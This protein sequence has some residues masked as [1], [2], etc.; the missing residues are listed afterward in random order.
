MWEARN[1][2]LE[3][4]VAIKILSDHLSRNKEVLQRF[5][6]EA[7]LSARAIHP[8]IVHVEDIGHTEEHVPFLVMEL[9]RGRSLLEVI[10]FRGAVS[11]KE[12]VAVLEALLD[13][14]AAAHARGILHRDVKPGNVFIVNDPETE[15]PVKILDLGL[16]KDLDGTFGLTRSEMVMGTPDYLAPELLTIEQKH[17]WS[18][19]ADVFA[20]GVIGYRLLGGRRPLD[21]HLAPDSSPLGFI[22]R[23]RFFKERF[24]AAQWADDLPEIVPLPIQKVIHQALAVDL[25]RRFGDAG[26]MLCALRVACESIKLKVSREAFV[27]MANFEP[28]L[29]RAVPPTAPEPTAPEPAAPEPTM[30]FNEWTANQGKAKPPVSSKFDAATVVDSGPPVPLSSWSGGPTLVDDSPPHAAEQFSPS[31]PPSLPPSPSPPPSPHSS[32]KG[33]I[34][35]AVVIVVTAATG[36]ALFSAIWG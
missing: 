30:A 27:D 3:R 6:R 15:V 18:A 1:I 9:L 35:G 7:K 5:I 2:A 25:G 34:I 28:E 24:E 26:E 23:A 31:P 21:G 32:R 19:A 14:L 20:V 10:E 33:F 8:V 12:G 29:P 13:G 17:A 11:L 22:A 16:A 4:P 36:L